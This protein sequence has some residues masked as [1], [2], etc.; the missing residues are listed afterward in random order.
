MGGEV[1]AHAAK[2]VPSNHSILRKEFRLAISL[3]QTETVSKK[4]EGNR[5][6]NLVEVTVNG[7]PL[8]PRHD[9][10]NHSPNGFEWGYGGSGPA[11]LSLALLADH[12]GDGERAARLHQ[13]FKRKVV[14][15]LPH[16]HWIL[17]SHEID[18][19]V[20]NLESSSQTGG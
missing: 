3:V 13:E 15:S 8:N 20:R 18:L 17:T 10:W 7:R 12:L 5:K 9:L 4:Y 1:A 19:V 16:D 11:Q 6:V 2:F 14:T